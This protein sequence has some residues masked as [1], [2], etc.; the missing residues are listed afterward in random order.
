MD[1]CRGNFSHYQSD[2][3]ISIVTYDFNIGNITNYVDVSALGPVN[4]THFANDIVVDEA[5]NA[6]ATDSFAG[7]LYKVDAVTGAA[8]VWLSDS[9]FLG[10]ASSNYFGANGIEYISRN[11][12]VAN[13][14]GVLLR[15][16]IDTKQVSKHSNH[17]D[18]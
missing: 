2:L 9:R 15:I 4:V 14:V 17:G 10:N 16:S 1:L 18:E 11:L 7:I 5:G 3:D 8:S 12:I 13:S 6:Y